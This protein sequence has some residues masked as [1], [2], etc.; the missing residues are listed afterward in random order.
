MKRFS[1]GNLLVDN[2]NREAAQVCQ[3]IAERRPVS[4]QPLVLVGAPGSGKTHLLYSIIDH[5][6]KTYEPGETRYAI[7]NPRKL[8]AEVRGQVRGL[9]RD[10]APIRSAKFALL[11][12]DQ[13]EAYLEET[14][15][16]EALVRVFLECGHPVVCASDIEL[17]RLQIPDSFRDLLKT[18]KS[19][20]VAPVE[21]NPVALEQR[22]RQTHEE[23]LER[24][25][26]E[27]EA[28]RTMS[29]TAQE[30]M[31]WRQRAEELKTEVADLRTQVQVSRAMSKSLER[32]LEDLR[33]ALY[34]ARSAPPP[35]EPLQAELTRARADL[36]RT[37][38]ELRSLKTAAAQREATVTA[39][40]QALRAELQ[41]V[42]QA[43]HAAETRA[44]TAE[45]SQHEAAA[46][47][48]ALNAERFRLENELQ[49]LREELDQTAAR[50]RS[51]E[52][53]KAQAL[54]E[55]GRLE[56]ELRALREQLDRA[57]A[58]AQTAIE[59]RN[60]VTIERDSVQAECEELKTRLA[61]E[62]GRVHALLEQ[63]RREA[64]AQIAAHKEAAARS[65]EETRTR[66]Q[67]LEGEL[68]EAHTQ[69]EERRG[70][71]DALAERAKRL[72]EQIDANR[73]RFAEV[74]AGQHR[75]IEELEA[76]LQERAVA[77]AS[78]EELAKVH[79]EAEE[80][81]ASLDELRRR[82][83]A[84]RAQLQESVRE[85]RLRLDADVSRIEEER[86]R[87]QRELDTACAERDARVE[88]MRLAAE[89]A[90]AETESLR[91]ESHEQSLAAAERIRTLEDELENAKAGAKELAATAS[92]REKEAAQ[93]FEA[94][95]ASL[96]EQL[97]GVNEILAGATGLL[98][99]ATECWLE[100]DAPDSGE[101]MPP[102][103]PDEKP[104]AIEGSNSPSEST[105]P[106]TE[107]VTAIEPD[108]EDDWTS[109]D[110]RHA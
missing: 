44:E 109:G 34:E 76:A 54:Q 46:S 96:T 78:A 17:D 24:Q 56:G 20:P 61:E 80:A 31:Q 67:L 88:E 15:E 33:V 71:S 110:E 35:E 2:D 37:G 42:R 52:D 62:Q 58:E 94:A 75:R 92:A 74:E 43:L 22:V 10:P 100:S 8:P 64:Q 93:R 12:V 57:N 105:L 27:G 13:L 83:D 102:Q 82:F 68:A 38:Q 23:A 89:H 1:F 7:L 51:A 108:L 3:D 50:L 107:P 48:D 9:V 14:D 41:H 97:Q 40:A 49:P 106:K 59:E 55:R 39:E 85:A 32:Q 25:R 26:R 47:Q 6:R 21:D 53:E 30:T 87:L 79:R 19:V 5:V 65:D 11:L 18:G 63:E 60:R 70:E 98:R 99:R 90:A 29:D 81:V 73:G 36:E 69:A 45:R 95:R 16:L 104:N 103:P 101:P 28:Q 4:P 66:I 91:R 72:V 77:A 84:E 86:R